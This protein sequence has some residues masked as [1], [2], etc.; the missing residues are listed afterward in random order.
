MQTLHSRTKPSITDFR[1]GYNYLFEQ[2]SRE[3]VV[4]GDHECSDGHYIFF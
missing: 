3:K 2:T 4:A 1:V